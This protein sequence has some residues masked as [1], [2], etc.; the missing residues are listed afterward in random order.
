MNHHPQEKEKKLSAKESLV[1]NIRSETFCRLA[2]SEI[3][4]VGVFAIKDIPKNIEIFSKVNETPCDLP[5][6]ISEQELKE[7]GEDIFI[8]TKD[9]LVNSGHGTFYLPPQGLNS[10]D[11]PFYLNHSNNPNVKFLLEG[12][13]DDFIVFV[14]SRDIKKGEE[15]TQDYNNLCINKD[16]LLEQFPFLR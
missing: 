14:S 13:L 9:M 11:I 3:S 16:K 4:G 1:N 6:E 2:P 5:V 10:I 8:Y 12:N 7:M 15:L